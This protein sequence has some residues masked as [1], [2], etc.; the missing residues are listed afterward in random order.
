MVQKFN[1]QKLAEVEI[2]RSRNWPNSKKKLAEVDRAPKKLPFS[3]EARIISDVN[4][5]TKHGSGRRE[6]TLTRS[7][8]FYAS[9]LMT[10]CVIFCQNC[11]VFLEASVTRGCS[12]SANSTS[13][14]STSASWP[15]S[16]LAEVEIGRSRNQ[17]AEV[18]H[19]VFV[20]FLLSLFFFLLFHCLFTFLYFSLVLTHLPLLFVFVL[21]LFRPQ[22]PELNP[23][24]RTLHPISD[25]PFRRPDNPPPAGQP[26]AGR[27]TLRR[28][29]IPPPAG[30]PSA[31]RTTLRPDN[32]PPDHPPPKISLFFFPLPA[33]IFI[34]LSLSWSF[35]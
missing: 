28:P 10:Y 33:T 31:G 15:K 20:L 2:G 14:N 25:G 9:R 4:S 12:T 26:S 19:M 34:L 35:L 7:S 5:L 21:F 16:N 17:L 23:K 27:T 8:F 6:G 29:D 3:H 24:P 32:P 30:Q 11:I 18:Q 22:K 1:I 13:D